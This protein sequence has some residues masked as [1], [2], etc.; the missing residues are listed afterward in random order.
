MG[1]GRARRPSSCS[2]SHSQ[3]APQFDVPLHLVFFEVLNPVGE[4]LAL[5]LEQL[6]A[7]SVEL[8]V[9]KIA[10]GVA[11]DRGSFRGLGALLAA[12]LEL[13]DELRK[14][15]DGRPASLLGAG[16]HAFLVEGGGSSEFLHRRL[17]VLSKLKGALVLGPIQD[18][19]H[20]G[21]FFVQLGCLIEA[22]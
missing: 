13:G 15:S 21:R 10:E 4:E 16:L 22:G 18:A 17:E 11:R 12:E 14:V 8:A 19:S 20:F 1:G 2:S 6:A 7:I 9:Q 5:L 3:V